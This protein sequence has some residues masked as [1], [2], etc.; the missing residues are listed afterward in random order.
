MHDLEAFANRLRKIFKARKSWAERVKTDAFRLYDGDIPELRYIVD[1]YGNQAV[2]FDK[3]VRVGEDTSKAPD[4]AREAVAAALHIPVQQVHFKLRRRMPGAQQYTRLANAER[5]FLVTE[6]TS[7]Y[8]VNLTDYLDTGLFLDHRPLRSEFRR[9][10][11]GTRFLNLFCYTGSV[12]VAA[13]Q[14][15]AKTVSVDMSNT[16]IEWAAANF[17]ANN[18]NTQ[19]HELVREDALVYLAAG[20]ARDLRFDVIFLDPPTFSNSKRMASSFDVQ[21][22]HRRLIDLAAKFLAEGGRLYFSTNRQKFHLDPA[23]AGRFQVEDLTLQTIPEDFRDK[24]VHRCYL[25]R[26][27]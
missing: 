15:G 25:L 19:D 18:I 27:K 2:V 24:K 6:E 1:I 5:F 17:V 13:A 14:S 11:R 12:S 4:A 7:R 9:L 8:R 10:A 3:S 16:Y 21:R 23:L 20:P 26:L 22:D